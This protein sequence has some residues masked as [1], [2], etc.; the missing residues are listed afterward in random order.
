MPTT[1]HRN[2]RSVSVAPRT[3][4]VGDGL[5]NRI[6]R[7]PQIGQ[8]IPELAFA[9]R[10]LRQAEKTK[11]SGCGGCGGKGKRIRRAIESAKATI[12]G[13]P[14]Q[15]LKQLKNM[16]GVKSQGKMKVFVRQGNRIV[17]V[18]V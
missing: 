13:M 4:M 10:I 12:A 15:R 8:Q 16:L 1:P 5:I 18:T 3:L 14:P 17:P 6:L 11:G 7:E 9:A 2:I